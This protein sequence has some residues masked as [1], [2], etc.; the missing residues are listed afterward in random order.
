MLT[1][2]SLAISNISF[3]VDVCSLYMIIIFVIDVLNFIVFTNSHENL[4]WV[5]DKTDLKHFY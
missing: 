4:Y 2:T 5:R 1:I 3:F